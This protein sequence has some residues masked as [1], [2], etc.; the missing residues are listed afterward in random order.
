MPSARVIV[1]LPARPDCTVRIA[2][3]LLADVG[4]DIAKRHPALTRAVLLSDQRSG[5]LFRSAVKDSLAQAGFRVLDITV[6]DGR[7]A[8]TAACVQEL[9]SAFAASDITAQTV[10]VALGGLSTCVSGLY[11]AAGYRGGMCTALVPTTLEAMAAAVTLPTA[12]VDLPEASCVATAVPRPSYGALSLD[13]LGDESPSEHQMGRA[14]LA[15]AALLGIHDELFR[16][17]E[18]ADAVC[19]NDRDAL[20]EALTLATIARADALA[21]CSADPPFTAEEQGFAYGTSLPRAIA[22]LDVGPV[23]RQGALLADSMRFEARLGAACGV[24][25]LELVQEQ[26]ALLAQLGLSSVADLPAPD[27]LA[28]ALSDL[29]GNPTGMIRLCVPTD[30]GAFTSVDFDP[31]LVLEHLQARAASL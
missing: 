15:R 8:V 13:T 25:P 2:G 23:N 30:A 18:L 29:P 28:A 24:T 10:L 17:E 27:E 6:P 12:A 26:D 20:A 3:S 1:E 16:M 21:Q 5:S 19:A 9:W 14:E 31:G 11:T 4:A 22:A 7:A